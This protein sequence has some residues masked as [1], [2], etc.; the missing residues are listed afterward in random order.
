MSVGGTLDAA[1]LDRRI[2]I[3][4]RTSTQGADG[5]EVVVWVLRVEL[6]AQ[7]M[8]TRGQEALMAQQHTADAEVEF[9]IRWRADV[10]QTDR[11]V[12]DS[13]NYDVQYL[14]E[15]GRRRKLRIVAKR[16]GGEG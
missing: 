7:V 5:G 10:R 8:H 2:R 11:I 12:Y 16:P 14:A 1:A 13:Q 15:M 4:Q 3:E 6:W 9:R